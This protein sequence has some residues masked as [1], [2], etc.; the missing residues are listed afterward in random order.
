M[1][2]NKKGQIIFV[3][4]MLAVVVF[5]V[6]GILIVPLKESADITQN[7]T[8]LNCTNPALPAEQQATCIMVDL[9]MFYFISV[10]IAVSIALLTG[11][12]TMASI[13]TAIIVYIVVVLLITPLKY[14][15][16]LYRSADYLNCSVST[17]SM[18]SKLLC[19]VIDLWLFLFVVSAI[20]AAITYITMKKTEE[21]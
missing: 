9:S 4:L 19:I 18:G 16:T 21:K 13:L 10:C 3:I 5:I 7:A 11:K 20:A 14:F 2:M 15:I 12:K 1:A 17:I 8:N 6:A